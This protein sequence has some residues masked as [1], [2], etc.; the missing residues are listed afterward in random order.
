MYA[1]KFGQENKYI[2]GKIVP[3]GECEQSKIKAEQMAEDNRKNKMPC[4]VIIIKDNDINTEKT[5]PQV[6]SQQT[7]PNTNKTIK[8]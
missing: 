3:I 5:T 7:T 8:K 1:I 6:Q 4:E 2:A